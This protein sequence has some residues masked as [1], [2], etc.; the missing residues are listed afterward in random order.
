[1]VVWRADSP[2]ARTSRLKPSFSTVPAH[3]ATRASSNRRRA[4]GRSARGDRNRVGPAQPGAGVDLAERGGGG[5]LDLVRPGAPGVGEE[6]F[7]L[8]HVD[9]RDRAAGDTDDE[10][11]ARQHRTVEMRMEIRDLA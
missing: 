8:G 9:R 11:D 3:T 2:A 1:M 6:L 4:A 10:L 7:E 5:R